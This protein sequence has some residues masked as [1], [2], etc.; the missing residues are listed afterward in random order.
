MRGSRTGP[1]NSLS[2]D[3]AVLS[4]R[5]PA[6]CALVPQRALERQPFTRPLILDVEAVIQK[7]VA[8]LVRA[9]ALR[10]LIRHAVVEPVTDL[11]SDVGNVPVRHVPGLV[12]PLHAVAAG[13]VGH[14]RFPGR[15]L[16]VT[17]WR[18]IEAAIDEVRE[19][20]PR[21]GGLLRHRNEVGQ[22]AEGPRIAV[23]GIKSRIAA[24]EEHPIRQR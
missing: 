14:R 7:A 18:R 20:H 22:H 4:S 11:P 15:V 12:A 16:L 8:G 3:D 17:R 2:A 24:L 1:P 6:G 9:H 10:Q 21:T 5:R 23:V 19:G 13:D